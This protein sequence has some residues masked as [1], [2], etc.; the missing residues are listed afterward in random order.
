MY[1]SIHSHFYYEFWWIYI[2][3]FSFCISTL[4]LVCSHFIRL[5]V[6]IY[7]SG[8]GEN[9]GKQIIKWKKYTLD[10]DM[11]WL[12]SFLLHDLMSCS[13]SVLFLYF[14]IFIHDHNMLHFIYHSW[15]YFISSNSTFIHI[16]NTFILVNV[17]A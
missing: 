13:Y 4:H 6:R 16:Q 17:N 11:I 9:E 5:S 2:F 14:S 1:T 12:V 7:M 3:F 8:S 15:D 10:N